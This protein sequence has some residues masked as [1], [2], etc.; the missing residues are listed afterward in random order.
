M[1]IYLQGFD[2][3]EQ[4]YSPYPDALFYMRYMNAVGKFV[5]KDI[6]TKKKSDNEQTAEPKNPSEESTD[7][8]GS[9]QS[10][11]VTVSKL[12]FSP[13][14]W[15]LSNLY[16][17]LTKRNSEKL[18]EPIIENLIDSSPAITNKDYW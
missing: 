3:Y 13:I 1:A 16:L 11:R 6:K 7:S 12:I 15:Q 18:I 8:V 5:T 2:D 14:Y 17:C 10:D 9:N 4:A